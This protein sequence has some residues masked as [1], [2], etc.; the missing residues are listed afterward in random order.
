[1]RHTAGVAGLDRPLSLDEIKDPVAFANLLA[2]QPHNFNGTRLHAYHAITQGWFQNE[3]IRRVD[4]Q[5]RTVDSFAQE[6]NKKYGIE[7]YLKPDV[8]EGVDLTRISQFYPKSDIRQLAELVVSLVKPSTNRTFIKTLFDKNSLF[9]K[10]I[11]NA[12]I[13][14]M[15]GV[16]NNNDPPRRAIEG[17]SYS[18]HTNADSVKICL[19]F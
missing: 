14:Q 17:P 16:M 18:G 4:P 8:T 1:M 2:S 11:K 15:K 19:Y 12:N 9:T 5:Q 10:C 6:L 7:W 13:D 3:L